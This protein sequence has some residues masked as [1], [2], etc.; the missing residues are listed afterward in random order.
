[1]NLKGAGIGCL[2]VAGM[3]AGVGLAAEAKASPASYIADLEASP[4]GFYGSKALWVTIGYGVCHRLAAG[5]NQAQVTDW[6]VRSTGEGV[7]T[8]QANYVVE[9]AE[10]HLCGADG[11]TV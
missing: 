7:Y 11:T 8:L 5:F 6:V 9:A 4:W 1:M 3:V 2:V 10:V